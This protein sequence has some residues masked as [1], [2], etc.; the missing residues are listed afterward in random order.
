M[1]S[2]NISQYYVNTVTIKQTFIKKEIDLQN[3]ITKPFLKDLVCSKEIIYNH[4]I[5]LVI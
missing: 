1:I 4:N 5:L 2:N 3:I